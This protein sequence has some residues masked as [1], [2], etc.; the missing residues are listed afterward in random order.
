MKIQVL[1]Q[2]YIITIKNHFV[3]VFKFANSQSHGQTDQR[4]AEFGVAKSPKFTIGG[5]GGVSPAPLIFL[6]GE[7]GPSY[8]L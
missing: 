4:I 5:L 2:I 7:I 6:T 8:K 1:L 3:Y